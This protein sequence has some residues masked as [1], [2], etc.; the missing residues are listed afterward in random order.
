[1][2]HEVITFFMPFLVYIYI[3]NFNRCSMRD[4][5]KIFIEQYIDLITENKFEELYRIAHREYLVIEDLTNSLLQA[6]V[7]PLKHMNYIPVKFLY[8][9]QKSVDGF[10]IP[11]G[12]ESIQQHAFYET[13]LTEIVIPEGVTSIYSRAFGSCKNLLFVTLPHSIKFIDRAVFIGCHAIVEIRYNGTIEEWNQIDCS[14]KWMS[15]SGAYTVKL[16][17]NDGELWV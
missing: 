4:L 17:C 10:V 5:T 3:L 6:D 9:S 7:N 16:I 2:W 1:M 13:D 15:L 14:D 8:E 12:I 11:D